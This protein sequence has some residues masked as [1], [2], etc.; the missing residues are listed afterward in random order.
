VRLAGDHVRLAPC[1]PQAWD[2]A[3]VTLRHGTA[4][5]VFELTQVDPSAALATELDGVQLA[6]PDHVPLSDDGA[7]HRV[8]VRVPRS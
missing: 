6:C 2:R 4:E 7:I 8:R 3:C 5:Y 1:L